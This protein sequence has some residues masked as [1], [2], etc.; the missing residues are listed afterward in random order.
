MGYKSQSYEN[1]AKTIIKNLEKRNMKG[2]YS[3]NS[4]ISEKGRQNHTCGRSSWYSA[5]FKASASD[6]GGKAGCLF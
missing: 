6:S 2:Y 1:Q 4:E 5:E 3:G